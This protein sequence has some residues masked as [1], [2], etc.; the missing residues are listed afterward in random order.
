[1]GFK[2]QKDKKLASGLV[3]LATWLKKKLSDAV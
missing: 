3:K 2:E 1:M